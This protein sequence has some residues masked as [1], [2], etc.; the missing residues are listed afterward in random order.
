MNKV[1]SIILRIIIILSAGFSILVSIFL[2]P[3]GGA[4]IAENLPGLTFWR[5]L[6]VAG[7][8]GAVACFIFALFQFWLLLNGIDKNGAFAAKRLR[9]IKFSAIAFSILYFVCAM[10]IFVLAAEADDAPG[11]VLIGAFF[12]LFPIGVASIAEIL[13][14]TV[15]K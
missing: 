2:L 4:A 15:G 3:A 6:I 9:A 10:P 12:D 11:L 7:L 13:E 14:K 1:P 5:Y 8:Y